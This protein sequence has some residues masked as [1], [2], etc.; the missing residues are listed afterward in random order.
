MSIDAR[1]HR[2]CAYDVALLQAL[3]GGEAIGKTHRISIEAIGGRA[4]T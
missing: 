1:R 4:Q 2:R 3:A